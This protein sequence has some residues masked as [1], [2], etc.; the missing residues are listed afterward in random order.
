MLCRRGGKGQP[1]KDGYGRGNWGSDQ[2]LIDSSEQDQQALNQE[3]EQ[4]QEV[5]YEEEE[6]E[7]PEEPEPTEISFEEYQKQ[8]AE[9]RK[10]GGE[11]F[12]TLGG[13]HQVETDFGDA[14]LLD[15]E[16]D[17]GDVKAFESKGKKLKKKNKQKKK[18]L[19]TD[20]GIRYE[21]SDSGGG[22]GGGGGY[23]KGGKGKGKGKGKGDRGGKGGGYKG[24]YGKGDRG[25][26]G[27]GR[28]V[29]MYILQMRALA[30]LAHFLVVIVVC[31][32][33]YGRKGGKGRRDF[34]PNVNN[35]AAFPALG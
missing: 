2:E 3:L 7:E 28:G 10:G 21:S 16:E 24:G 14:Q 19:L 18:N 34:T 29:L 5:E 22:G 11:A 6:E 4:E 1:R 25:G 32:S 15:K 17:L 31:L 13:S 20:I 33:G 12:R 9:S 8:L 27:G 23:G 35:E 26:K 30:L